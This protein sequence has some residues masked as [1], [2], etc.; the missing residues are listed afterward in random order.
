MEPIE[1]PKTRKNLLGS[2]LNNI[3]ATKIVARQKA[4]DTVWERNKMKFEKQRDNHEERVFEEVNPNGDVLVKV[5]LWKKIDE[6]RV[7][8]NANVTVEVQKEDD[9]EDLLK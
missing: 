1:R 7:V 2:L 8:V 5:E 3:R 6:E 9:V 4:I